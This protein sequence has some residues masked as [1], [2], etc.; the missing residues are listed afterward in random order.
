MKVIE[1]LYKDY[2]KVEGK[3]EKRPGSYDSSRKTIEVVVPDSFEYKLE[4]KRPVEYKK[5]SVCPDNIA[6][7]TDK[8]A[9]IKL[10]YRS[11]YCDFEVWISRKLLRGHSVTYAPDFKFCAKKGRGDTAEK[12]ELT[13]DE[14]AEI[15]D[16]DFKH[17]EYPESDI[18]IPEK[19]EPVH[20][21]ILEELKDDDENLV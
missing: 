21:E 17:Q 19:L 4:V 12:I 20:T 11:D 2:K 5:F 3:Y 9:C 14:L 7:Y 10:P 6:G 16:C 18:H 13:G 1:M 8:A 15:F